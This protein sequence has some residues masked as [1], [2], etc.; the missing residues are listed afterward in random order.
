MAKTIVFILGTG[1]N[2]STLL[3]MS[4]NGHS[5]I[6]SVGEIDHLE[7]DIISRGESRCG[8]YTYLFRCNFWNKIWNTIKNNYNYQSNPFYQNNG[9]LYKNFRR[10]VNGI[11]LLLSLLNI[12]PT[13]P[14]GYHS[15]IY[16]EEIYSLIFKNENNK[17]ISDS[18]KDPKRAI[19]I[20]N[21][22]KNF[23]EFKFIHLVRDGRAVVNSYMKQEETYY[24]K[25]L[26]GEKYKVSEGSK[27]PKD[28]Q[29]FIKRWENR[30]K[31]ILRYIKPFKKQSYILIRYEDF[32]RYPEKELKRICEFLDIDFQESM[33]YLDSRVNHII[34]GNP[35]AK[36]KAKTINP[37]N[38][39]YFV[40][41]NKIELE[42]FN[43]I[44]GSL[45]KKFGY[46]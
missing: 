27:D 2:G 11:D 26:Y 6:F 3:D 46:V 38:V 25:N 37:P 8:C 32:C 45:N 14:H 9:L 1:R 5:E 24:L 12:W 42:K 40:N 16:K 13:R 23:Y 7:E 22:L 36:F 30:N 44:A 21:Y 33:L 28:V 31:E 34:R 35:T 10:V 41:L 20:S 29:K 4:L 15:R 19:R 39:N 43:K 18:M 17:I